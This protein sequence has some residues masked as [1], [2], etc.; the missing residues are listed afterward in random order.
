MWAECLHTLST[1]ECPQLIHYGSYETIFLRHM[2]KRYPNCENAALLDQ[3]MT[4]AVNLLSI[5]Y[6]RIYFPTYSNGLKDIA[7]HLGFQWSDPAAAGAAALGWRRQWE[8]SRS[9]DQKQTLLTYNAE[10]CAAAQVVTEALVALSVSGDNANV[11]DVIKLKREYPQRFGKIEFVMPEFEQI[12]NAARWDYQREKVYVR[13]SK[14]LHRLQRMAPKTRHGVP[15]NKVI[16][17]EELRPTC[18]ATCGGTTIYRF[19]RLTRFVHDLKLSGNGIRRWI[20]QYSF[21]RY[22]CWQCKSTF[23]QF[24]H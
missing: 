1:I 22:I 18:C 15:V 5:I 23:H 7:R 4:S 13:S 9:S 19:G 14:R 20:V 16:K 11:V 10:D 24:A 3:L 12:N 8:F 21:P 2:N 17:W 6:P